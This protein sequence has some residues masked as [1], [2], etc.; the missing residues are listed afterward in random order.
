MPSS[1]IFFL[2]LLAALAGYFLKIRGVRTAYIWMVL[3]F[4]SFLL[5]LALLIIPNDR[6]VPII[7]NDWFRFGETR[8]SLQF[9][10]NPQNWILVFSLFVINLSFFLTGITRLDIK[11]D[12]KVWI[13]QLL[14]IALSFLALISADLWSVILLWTAIDLLELVFHRMIIK[15]ANEKIYF[16]KFIIKIY[17]KHCF[18]MEYCFFSKIRI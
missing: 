2:C 1:I 11:S 6:F 8:I 4:I 15:D 9:A 5:W 12:L 14:L 13:I 17:R 3:V 18:D 16:R 10:I 7:L